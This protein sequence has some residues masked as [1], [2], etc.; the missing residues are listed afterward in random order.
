[1]FYVVFLVKKKADM[2]QEEFTRYWI[3]EHTPLTAKM[4]G[5]RA[6][7]CFPMTSHDSEAPPFEAIA[8]VAFDD[9]AAWRVAEQSPEFQSALADSPNFQTVEATKAFYAERHVIV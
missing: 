3:E 1:M 2:T 7:H 5:L 6:Y 8:Y 9:E 4:P